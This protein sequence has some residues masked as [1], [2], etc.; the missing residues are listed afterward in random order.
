MTDIVEVESFDPVPL[1]D[2]TEKVLGG[3]DGPSNKQA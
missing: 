2:Q 3:V 1:L